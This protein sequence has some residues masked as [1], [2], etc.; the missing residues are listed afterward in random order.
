MD[1]LVQFNRQHKNVGSVLDPLFRDEPDLWL[2]AFND[3]KAAKTFTAAIVEVKAQGGDYDE[4]V[5][6][7]CVASSAVSARLKLLSEDAECG[8]SGQRSSEAQVGEVNVESNIMEKGKCKD[9]IGEI[10]MPVIGWVIHGHF[11]YLHI[12]YRENDNTIVS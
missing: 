9:K 4:G 11:W 3:A 12:A 10:D 5:Y 7:F 2:S 8:E 6:Q 1:H